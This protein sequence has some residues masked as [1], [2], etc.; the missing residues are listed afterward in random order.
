M[1]GTQ[2]SDGTTHN[3]S[4]SPTRLHN[5]NIYAS[6]AENLLDRSNF[7]LQQ[8]SPSPKKIRK[9]GLNFT[10]AKDARTR[11]NINLVPGLS[12]RKNNDMVDGAV[13]ETMVRLPE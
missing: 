8:H 1:R 10:A 12:K 9:A 6:D 4:V 3:F 2:T 5:K 7:D 11:I 13:N